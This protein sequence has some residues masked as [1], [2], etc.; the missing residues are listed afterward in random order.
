M[1]SFHQL[2]WRKCR[3]LSESTV[4]ELWC[5]H[6]ES[7]R[8]GN[9]QQ[10]MIQIYGKFFFDRWI[11]G[12][13]WCAFLIPLLKSSIL[14]LSAALELSTA[15][16]SRIHLARVQSASAVLPFTPIWFRR[17]WKGIKPKAVKSTCSSSLD[18]L[19]SNAQKS[20]G[21]AMPKPIEAT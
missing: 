6:V 21:H 7:A 10:G 5:I 15:Q 1:T 9:T 20:P 8:S 19:D 12:A 18:S 16:R 14:R 13:L 3:F 11:L 2:N 17:G 4:W